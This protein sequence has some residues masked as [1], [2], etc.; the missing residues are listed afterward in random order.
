MLITTKEV[1]KKFL[2]SKDIAWV[3][4]MDAYTCTFQSQRPLAVEDMVLAF[5]KSSTMLGRVM[6]C[7]RNLLVKPFDLKSVIGDVKKAT[8]LQ[9]GEKIGLFKIINVAENEIVAGE[10][11]K[12]LDYWVSF[13]LNCAE[14]EEDTYQFTLSTSVLLHNF[15]GRLYFLPVKFFHKIIV[16]VMIRKMIL[17]LKRGWQ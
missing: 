14:G 8:S 1:T 2:S 7:L 9:R 16:P 12:H 13:Y 4:Y 15:L 11:D 6:M 10:E 5:S 17:K 3:D